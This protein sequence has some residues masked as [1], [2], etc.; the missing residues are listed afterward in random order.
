[1]K[2]FIHEQWGWG[3]ARTILGVRQTRCLLLGSCNLDSLSGIVP[4]FYT[5]PMQINLMGWWLPGNRPGSRHRT[6]SA[7]QV[8]KS[9]TSVWHCSLKHPAK[10]PEIVVSFIGQIRRCWRYG[11]IQ[12]LNL[13][14]LVDRKIETRENNQTEL[15]PFV[16][17]NNFT[18]E[19][20][21]SP[22][23]AHP[24]LHLESPY[25]LFIK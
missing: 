13:C 19:I 9:R 22:C 3:S 12:S 18:G 25:V 7:S 10:Y 23:H 8:L 14:C 15:P 6:F 2:G 4:A 5:Q 17:Q 24:I 16:R 20:F 1:M 11:P 21:P